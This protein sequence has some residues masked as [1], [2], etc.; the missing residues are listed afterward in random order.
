[1]IKY[2]YFVH[3]EGWSDG[4][5]EDTSF[6]INEAEARNTIATIND[7]Y[8][9]NGKKCRVA[10]ISFEEITDPQFVEANALQEHIGNCYGYPA[11]DILN[12]I[13]T[14]PKVDAVR[15]VHAKWECVNESENVW[16]CTGEN[17]CGNEIILLERTPNESEW[18]YCPH[19]GAKMD[20]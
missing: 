1:M 18:Y 16:M 10:F 2:K 4:G 17:G 13:A 20:A 5:F 6:A 3:L 19:C 11:V 8:E 7:E 14:F 15:L 12:E 9:K